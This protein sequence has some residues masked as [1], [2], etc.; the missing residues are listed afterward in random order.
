MAVSITVHERKDGT[1]VAIVHSEIPHL[2]AEFDIQIDSPTAGDHR[3][4]QARAKRL[5]NLFGTAFLH[6]LQSGDMEWVPAE[7][8]F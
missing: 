2:H 8:R 5:L 3:P 4:S 6:T 1:M 7:K